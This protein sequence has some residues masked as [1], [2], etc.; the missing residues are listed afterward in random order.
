MYI[1]HSGDCPIF[2][3]FSCY[4]KASEEKVPEIIQ[5]CLTFLQSDAMF[6][7]LSDLTGLNF[8]HLAHKNVNVVSGEEDSDSEYDDEDK[9]SDNAECDDLDID[10]SKPDKKRQKLDTDEGEVS[11][12]TTTMETN[13]PS[14]ESVPSEGRLLIDV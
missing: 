11:S 2:S 6:L 13:V 7:T 5:Q 3:N 4:M 10:N 14:T 8:H 12:E 9:S 1:K